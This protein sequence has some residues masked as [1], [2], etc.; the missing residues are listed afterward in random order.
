M[1]AGPPVVA[2]PLT[3][4]HA[5]QFDALLGT[6]SRDEALW[7]SGYLAGFARRTNDGVAPDGVA[8]GAATVPPLTILF[9]SETGHAAELARRMAALAE[10]R[11]LVARVIDMAEFRP[12]EL[13]ATR[14]MV[15]ITSTYGEGEPPDHAAGFHEFLHGR[16]APRL[17]GTKFAVLGIGDSSYEH[18]CQTGKDFD[19]RLEALGAE[20]VHPRADCDVDYD[21]QAAEWID[22]ALAAFAQVMPVAE[23]PAIVAAA[24]PAAVTFDKRHPFVAPIL[25]SQ[26]ITGR[27]SDKETRHL[28]LAVQGAGIDYQPGDSLAVLADNNPALVDDLITL[29][30]LDRDEL[31][32]GGDQDLPLAQALSHHWEITTATPHFV[33]RWAESSRDDKLRAAA[34]PESRG[35]L[36]DWLAGR[37]IIDI[38][39][40][41]PVQALSGR[42]FVAM[43]R[44]L[45]PR[46]YSLASSLAA[47]P[48]EAHLTVAVLRYHYRGRDRLGVASAWLAG[49]GE[50]DTVPVY[51]QPNPNFRLPGPGIPII[52][53]GAGT[54]IAP[55]RA[56]L[57]EREAVGAGGRNWLFFGERRFRTDFLYQ[58]EWQ[59]LLKDGRLTRM[60]VAFS[61]DGADKVYVQHRLLERGRD[62]FAWLEEGAHLYV[63]GD[64]AGLAPGVHAAL[65]AIAQRQGAMGRDQAEDYVKR[66]QREQRY[67]RDVY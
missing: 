66:L 35:A 19:R 64:S 43:L 27:G 52:M 3:P 39:A 51:L 31:V 53:V 6:L 14:A 2:T 10:G 38:A 55:F 47:F 59:R 8:P 29:L 67:Q 5:R 28:E 18:F 45:Q 37:Q 21:D 33:E 13:K 42:S 36:K 25:D 24:A 41:F 49:R 9:G 46:L 22:S 1:T 61:R 57:Q 60:D 12:Q 34:A 54:G 56:F 32:P 4:D 20:R 16:K 65:I 40:E 30:G 7:L 11:G 50:D 62:V 44:R 17:E 63:C 23:A 26:V 48:G 15:V 58:L